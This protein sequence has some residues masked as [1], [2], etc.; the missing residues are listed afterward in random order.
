MCEPAA[1]IYDDR[2]ALLWFKRLGDVPG[3]EYESPVP[4]DRGSLPRHD[5]TP[6]QTRVSLFD[7]REFD[8]LHW[9][10]EKKGE[11]EDFVTGRSPAQDHAW[12]AD[13]DEIDSEAL[14]TR[15]WE[16]L[17]LPGEPSDYHFA[18]QSAAALLWRRKVA[19]PDVLRWCEYLFRLDI[20]LIESCPDAIRNRYAEDDESQAPYY[21]ATAFNS[22]TSMYEREGYL[23]E[24]LDVATVAARFGQ[25]QSRI[26]EVR[27]RLEAVRAEDGG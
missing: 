4:I 22:L 27:E 11:Y 1:K 24:A 12:A 25:E 16:S 26:D 21:Q 18:M 17:E 23:A 19:E 6:R 14:R 13:R 7:G 8:E 3:I 9:D 10:A 2:I 5:A 20:R 15:L